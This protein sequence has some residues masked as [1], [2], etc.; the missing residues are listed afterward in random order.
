MRWTFA[1]VAS[2]MCM[3]ASA[4][5]APSHVVWDPY[6]GDGLF[7]FFQQRYFSAATDLMVS[8]HF[9][10]LPHHVDEAE[11]LR[12]GLYL[13]YG[14]HREAGEI[15]ARLIEKTTKPEVRDRAWYYLAKIRYQRDLPGQAE[16]A[17]A[18]VGDHLPPE[19]EEDRAL[20]QANLL[21]ARGAYADAAKVL[22]GLANNAKGGVYVRYNLGVALIKSG[23]VEQGTALLDQI[24]QAPAESDEMLSLRDK[25]NVA[26]GFTAL[27]HNDPDHATT[28]LERVRLSG[29]LANKALLGFGWAAATRKQPKEAL[30]P[31]L[32]LSK[33]STTD[34]AVLEAKLAVPYAMGEI[35]AY[36]QSLELY[37][38]AISV[39]ERERA[40][41]DESIAAIHAGKLLQGL[42]ERN[43]G[44]EEMGWFWNIDRLPK[45]PHAEHLIP[46][47]AR[48]DFQ[49]AFKNYRDLLF[50]SKNLHEWQDK[51]GVYNDMLANRRQAFAERLPK[52][53]AKGG[54]SGL[55]QLEQQRD[56]LERELTWAEAQS[57]VYA[58][59]DAKEQQLAERLTGVRQMLDRVGDDPRFENERE[60]YRRV[61][62]A[63]TWQLTQEYPARLWEAKKRLMDLDTELGQARER[64][65]ALAQAQQEEP[66]HF[67]QFAARTA[68]LDW[69]I[70]SLQP[71]VAALIHA[72]DR[73]MQGL[74][75]AELEHQKDQLAA[76][77]TQARFAVA[78]I[79]DR[80][81][82]G[83]TGDAEAGEPTQ[84]Q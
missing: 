50:L 61:A 29:M 27:Q 40:N 35:G 8:Q 84:G 72:Q 37:N 34:A 64:D 65:T 77:A 47:L 62:G 3:A 41:L 28:Y 53:R 11:L 6:Y 78:R 81:S 20:L 59:T 70:R 22:Q 49:E 39:F 16:E 79:Y 9:A 73:Y 2:A 30:V 56:E 45:L 66:A 80:A 4:A 75:V 58:F 7:Y 24:G 43:A 15:F 17:L 76:Y 55:D 68:Q 71:R 10:R 48:H 74:A 14:M 42:L 38:D 83:K 21:M 46:V 36:S 1:L 82:G 60:R 31:W 32:E 67:E 18:H 69:R 26:L 33:R 57:N 19:L 12:G 25:A 44:E 52:I 13:S 51:L 63:L 54:S 5:S 23:Q